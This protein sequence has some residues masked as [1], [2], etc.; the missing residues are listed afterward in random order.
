MLNKKKTI[1]LVLSIVYL[2]IVGVFLPIILVLFD[3][4]KL[5]FEIFADMAS[6]GV[7][8]FLFLLSTIFFFPF[9]YSTLVKERLSFNIRDSKKEAKN[10]RFLGLIL[11]VI[12]IPLLV[13]ILIG[14]VAYYSLGEFQGGFGELANNGFLVLL[15]M[16]LYFGIFPAFI[17]SFKK[18]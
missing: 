8:F 10:P 11:F 5:I 6:I 2:T 15:I 13:L 1:F 12:G 16:D 4:Y 3:L 17:L 18:K 14:I 9:I 7:F